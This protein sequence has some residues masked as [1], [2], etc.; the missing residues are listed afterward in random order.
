[1]YGT[2][3]DFLALPLCYQMHAYTALYELRPANCRVL[4]HTQSKRHTGSRSSAAYKGSW[5]TGR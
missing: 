4:E 5:F 2:R 3:L 1:M